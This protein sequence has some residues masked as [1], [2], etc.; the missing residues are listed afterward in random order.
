MIAI[1]EIADLKLARYP[2]RP[3]E[4]LQAW[5]AADTLL[6]RYVVERLENPG[7][8]LI[9]NDAWGA[10]ATATAHLRLTPS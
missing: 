3:K 4:T 1:R 5:D 7:T 2:R 10:L 9:V 8:I 6:L